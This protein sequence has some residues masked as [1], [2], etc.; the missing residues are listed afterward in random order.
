MSKE[1]L[2]QILQVSA[3]NPPP[4]NAGPPEMRAWF[5]A[6]NEQTPIPDGATIERISCGPVDGDSIGYAG[7]ADDAVI[8]YYHG[9]GFLFGSSRSHRVIAANLARASGIPVVAPDYRLAPEHPAPAA[10]DDADGTYL[11]ALDQG[12][13]PSRIA[14]S[15]DSAGGNLAL[16][17]AV[18][19]R[20]EGKPVPGAIAVMSP[21]LDLADDGD[22]HHA[23][24]DAPLLT[25]ELMSLFN[26]VYV[27]PG[28]R[29]SAE[30]TPLHSDLSSLPPVLVHV[31]SWELLRDDAITVTERITRAGG[32]A[33]LKIFDGMCH[34]WQLFTPMLDEGMQSIE[35]A[36]RFMAARLG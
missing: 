19:A 15:G 18:R 14:L 12:Y 23:V 3:E 29:R 26:A 1:Q 9:G 35:E 2:A 6:I 25:P 5:E 31:G 7:A 11:W 4:E 17:A 10:H 36:A 13:P 20:D 30:V 32:E 27:G 28:D 34:S 21:A 8:I 16:A 33:T 24:L 22:S